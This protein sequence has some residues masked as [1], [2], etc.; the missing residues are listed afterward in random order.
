M[1]A[2]ILKVSGKQFGTF[3]GEYIYNAQG[4]PIYRVDGDEVYN[5]EMPCKYVGVYENGKINWLSSDIHIQ[6]GD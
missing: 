2:V 4:K 6:I 3:D 5:M 1:K